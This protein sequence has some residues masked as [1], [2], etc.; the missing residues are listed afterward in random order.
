V[1][2]RRTRLAA[3]STLKPRRRRGGSAKEQKNI[4]TEKK[5]AC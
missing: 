3:K 4:E 1:E 2:E 5:T